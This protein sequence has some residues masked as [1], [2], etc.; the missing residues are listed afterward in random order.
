MISGGFG[1]PDVLSS[2]GLPIVTAVGQ[3]QGAVQPLRRDTG[4]LGAVR[5]CQIQ[6]GKG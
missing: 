5:G 4:A 6:V 1:S 2:V 3:P